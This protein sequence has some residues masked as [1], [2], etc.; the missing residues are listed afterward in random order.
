MAGISITILQLSM[1]NEWLSLHEAAEL[2]G[3]HPS[4]VRAW[5]NKGVLPVHRTQGG[6]RR[7]RR[8]EVLL[9]ANTM[10]GGQVI[11]PANV[12]QTAVR[13]I[14]MQISEGRLEAEPWY[15]K[16]DESARVQ[17]RQSAH[18]LFQGLIHYLS[19]DEIDAASEAHSIGYEY[20]SRARRFGLDNV[21]ASRAFLFFRDVLLQSVIQV[22]QEANIPSGQAWG[23]ILHKVNAFTDMILLH[24]LDTY[25]ALENA[26]P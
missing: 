9:W 3:V 2:L 21:D 26:K 11:E 19:S 20:A 25:R 24:L 18:T 15:R 13:N 22:Y 12:V 10:R 16:L 1:E 14:R 4:T 5:S 7:Y 6:H 23:E 17:Y 8:N